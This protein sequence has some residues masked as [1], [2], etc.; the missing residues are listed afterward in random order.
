MIVY[1]ITLFK[2]FQTNSILIIKLF[3]IVYNLEYIFVALVKEDDIQIRGHKI[4]LSSSSILKMQD[5]Q[6]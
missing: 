1:M 3:R 2:Y 6:D 4:K 5:I